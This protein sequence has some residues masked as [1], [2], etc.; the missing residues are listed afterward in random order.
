[1]NKL[2]PRVLVNLHKPHPKL[3]ILQKW[4]IFLALDFHQKIINFCSRFFLIWGGPMLSKP[5]FLQ[6]ETHFFT[7]RKSPHFGIIFGD[8]KSAPD[9][10]KP[11]FLTLISQH[12]LI[13]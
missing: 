2:S 7:F 6:Y 8:Q 1:M 12:I 13:S 11:S 5:L 10:K 9:L 4:V 3:K